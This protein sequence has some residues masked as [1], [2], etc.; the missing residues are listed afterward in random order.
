M[1]K[2]DAV[3]MEVSDLKA[4]LNVTK[5]DILVDKTTGN[6]SFVHRGNWFRV[7]KDIDTSLPMAFMT[8]ETDYDGNPDWS[9]GCLVNVDRSNSKKDVFASF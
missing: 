7:Q 1:S 9:L 8:T 5:I 3:F 4:M 6:K 2:Q